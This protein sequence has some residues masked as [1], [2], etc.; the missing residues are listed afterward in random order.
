MRTLAANQE[1]EEEA[2]EVVEELERVP[3]APGTPAKRSSAQ[4]RESPG[5]YRG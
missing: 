2:A 5:D 4:R 3:A 1:E